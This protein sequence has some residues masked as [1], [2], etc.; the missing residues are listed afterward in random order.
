MLAVQN[1]FPDFALS[2][3]DGAVRSLKRYAG[4]WLVVYFYPKDNTSGCSNEATD[5]AA[6]NDDFNTKKTAVLGVSADSVKSHK[7]FAVKLNLPF[8]LL[9][10]PEHR[11]LE[12]CGVWQKKKM[13]G[14]EYMGIVRSTFLVDPQGVV[15]AAWS[16]VS[17]A[18]HARDVL[19]TL[20][21]LQRSAG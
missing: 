18:G 19:S 21:D 5:F 7:N 15:R 9:S 2:D 8:R 4:K 13:A 12:K 16:K 11:L 1:S 10:D 20:T 17:V 14:R 6:L 3:Q